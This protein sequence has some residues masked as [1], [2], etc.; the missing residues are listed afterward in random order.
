MFD[1]VRVAA[2]PVGERQVVKRECCAL[3]DAH[4]DL[5]DVRVRD[6]QGDRQSQRSRQ[7]HWSLARFHEHVGKI[8]LERRQI[9]RP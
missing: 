4:A 9:D 5:A 7:L 1:A 8:D 3:P 6:V 2:A